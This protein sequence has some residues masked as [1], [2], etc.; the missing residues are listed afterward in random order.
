MQRNTDYSVRRTFPEATEE[1]LGR[2]AEEDS[3][4]DSISDSL[5]LFGSFDKLTKSSEN[6]YIDFH[7]KSRGGAEKGSILGTGRRSYCTSAKPQTS[8]RMFSSSSTASRTSTST[9]TSSSSAASASTASISNG[10]FESSYLSRASDVES[11]SRHHNRNQ[12]QIRNLN[13]KVTFSS[14]F[15][16]VPTYECFNLCTYCNFRTNVRS[17]ESKMMT[18]EAVAETLTRL[19]EQNESRPLTAVHEILIL[20][21]I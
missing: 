7:K 9:S 6:R 19:R 11:Y 5:G 12:N 8:S 18:M 16:I 17:D 15:T 4:L 10:M 21:G 2:F 13:R 20:S 3:P 1:S 14:S